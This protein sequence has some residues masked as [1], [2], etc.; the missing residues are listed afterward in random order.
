MS[1][2]KKHKFKLLFS[3]LF[4]S[5]VIGGHYYIE[6]KISTILA[7]QKEK[8]VFIDKDKVELNLFS[9][10]PSVK[11]KV[12]DVY[13]LKD[14]NG[15]FI[16]KLKINAS[17]D[18]KS[19]N[20]INIKNISFDDMKYF[21]FDNY[22]TEEG[23]YKPI[24]KN[25][26][27]VLRNI[28]GEVDFLS[29]KDIEVKLTDLKN[30]EVKD[31]DLSFVIK[32]IDLFKVSEK[33]VNNLVIENLKTS[34]E[35]KEKIN[36][37]KGMK[38]KIDKVLLKED[39]SKNK[40]IT[41][42]DM[43]LSNFNDSYVYSKM[44]GIVL[45]K[46]NQK[47]N[48]LKEIEG[49][50]EFD[51]KETISIKH[52]PLKNETY[53][54]SSEEGISLL[55]IQKLFD[56]KKEKDVFVDGAL[57]I[58]GKSIVNQKGDRLTSLSIK[59]KKELL[60]KN[61]DKE[62]EKKDSKY[63]KNLL[64]LIDMAGVRERLDHL[65]IRKLDL[66]EISINSINKNNKPENLLQVRDGLVRLTNVTMS[67]INLTKENNNCDGEFDLNLN[68]ESRKDYKVQ[69]TFSGEC[70]ELKFKLNANETI[71]KEGMKLLEKELNKGF[72]KL[73]EELNK[74]EKIKEF[75][76]LLKGFFNKK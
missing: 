29:N 37:F 67:G 64:N 30:E 51:N 49:K 65:A 76:P 19:K 61:L 42:N 39:G 11:V 32:N 62:V 68:K 35:L 74:D 75:V 38:L 20:Y 23:K 59:D 25:E 41:L 55:P 27:E 50:I 14:H 47:D 56:L 73:E 12:K 21:T 28:D 8:G 16:D 24:I 7:Q 69:T 22:K 71:K 13:F 44:K 60:I 54:S 15:V 26:K 33:E 46:T 31:L 2:I 40:T 5:S 45:L 53:F 17:L 48:M 72:K 63:I 57:I 70:K 58:K 6:Q 52:F 1:F 36:N 18:F 10:S 43:Y 66:P 34:L 4:I 9:F 3:A